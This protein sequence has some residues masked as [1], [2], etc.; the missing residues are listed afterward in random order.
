MVQLHQKGRRAVDSDEESDELERDIVNED[1]D[2][3]TEK[4]YTAGSQ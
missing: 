2:R 4:H 3:L 1:E